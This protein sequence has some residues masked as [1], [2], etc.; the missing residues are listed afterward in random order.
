MHTVA[1]TEVA[2]VAG[3]ICEPHIEMRHRHNVDVQQGRVGDHP[4]RLVCVPRK[5][6][7]ALARHDRVCHV[8]GLLTAGPLGEDQGE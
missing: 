7:I 4:G 2:D 6:H 3:G 1:R 5:Q 8:R